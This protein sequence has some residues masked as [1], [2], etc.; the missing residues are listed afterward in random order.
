MF[1]F[2]WASQLW[3]KRPVS[4][5]K[6]KFENPRL[7]IQN[8]NSKTKIPKQKNKN[9]N[10]K[11]QNQ[12][13]KTQIQVWKFVSRRLLFEIVQ[14]VFIF[15]LT[16]CKVESQGHAC[17]AAILFSLRLVRPPPPP[18]STGLIAAPVDFTD[19]AYSRGPQ[20][21][22]H[23]HG[24]QGDGDKWR[25]RSC[26]SYVVGK[27]RPYLPTHRCWALAHKGT[28]AM[29]RYVQGNDGD[30]EASYPAVALLFALRAQFQPEWDVGVF[31]FPKV[32][33]SVRSMD[34]QYVVARTQ[35]QDL[36]APSTKP[37]RRPRT[38]SG[39]MPVSAF[40]HVVMTGY[41]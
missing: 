32:H 41:L 29:T 2:A 36:S 20:A 21:A 26:A 13:T 22:P 30:V 16:I 17:F 8:S 37:R 7:R 9:Q 3:N 1:S 12:K 31:L 14:A 18:P 4:E 24:E 28:E 25:V 15:R 5:R 19:M 11:F 34:A 38:V 33:I 27:L 39:L 40:V 6:G 10:Q 23:L 35:R